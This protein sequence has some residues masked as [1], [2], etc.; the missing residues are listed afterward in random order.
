CRQGVER[1]LNGEAKFLAVWSDLLSERDPISA[2]PQH[3]TDEDLAAYVDGLA[4]DEMH[5]TLVDHL[6][7]CERCALAVDDLNI[8]KSELAPMLERE[9]QPST[10]S[11][12]REP[13]RR[14]TFVARLLAFRPSPLLAYGAAGLVLI[15]LGLVVWAVLRQP[16]EQIKQEVVLPVPSLPENV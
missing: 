16:S 10:V 2:L 6:S 14:D 13:E 7:A 12:S 8:L 11:V 3:P 15:I 5:R 9:Y 4:D 1:A